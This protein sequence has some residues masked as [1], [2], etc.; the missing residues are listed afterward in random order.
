M[1]DDTLVYR[2]NDK[3]EIE[4]FNEAWK[5]FAENNQGKDLA[6]D[7][8]LNRPIWDFVKDRTTRQLYH[9]ILQ[10][11]RSRTPA[12]VKFTIRCDSPDYR[13]L[14]EMTVSANERSFVEFRARTI[15]EDHREYQP[16]LDPAVP[17]SDDLL[18]IC[19]W[20]KKVRSGERWLEI[21]DAIKELELFERDRLPGLTHGMCD[22]CFHRIKRSIE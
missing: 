8:I 15:S 21:E 22:E 12:P 9:D 13:R 5:T 20:C 18:G 19:G 7:S 10:T 3:D 14:L 11:V 1:A 2:L 6:T 4:S 16:L 17:R